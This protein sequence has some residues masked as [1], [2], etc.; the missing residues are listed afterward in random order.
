MKVLKLDINSGHQFI[1]DEQSLNA[2]K[3]NAVSHMYIKQLYNIIPDT[4]TSWK[5]SY[6]GAACKLL[7]RLADVFYAKSK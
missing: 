3:R 5:S 6:I 7:D 2:L 4:D 1:N